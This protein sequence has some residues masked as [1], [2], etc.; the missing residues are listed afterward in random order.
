[1]GNDDKL[2]ERIEKLANTLF[3]SESD[4]SLFID[5]LLAGSSSRPLKICTKRDYVKKI[6]AN[7]IPNEWTRH[8]SISE[9]PNTGYS[10]DC[11]SLFMVSPLI[12]VLNTKHPSPRICDMCASP[13]GKSI[14]TQLITSPDILISNEIEESRIKA[15]VSN[16]SK[17]EIK[18][19]I[20]TSLNSKQLIKY[21]GNTFDVVILDAP[22]SGQSLIS[23]GTENTQSLSKLS[24]EK[25]SQI[26]KGLIND[27]AKLCAPG[28][29]I[30]YSTCTYSMKENEKVVE[31]FLRKNPAFESV[32]ITHLTRYRSLYSKQFCYRLWPY[33]ELGSG[34]FCC[35][36][37]N[38]SNAKVEFVTDETQ[39]KRCSLWSSKN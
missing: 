27:A 31:W 4:K 3:G 12:E 7:N 28:G 36:L 6:A 29:Y 22:C 14:L 24:I 8:W 5:T 19:A 32:E 9:E 21:F 20:V 35:L 16:F 38:N 25:M 10:I 23:K 37:R 1:M 11:S 17:H 13:G 18:N 2:R 15:L 26:Q 34:G 33:Q 39:L 30:N